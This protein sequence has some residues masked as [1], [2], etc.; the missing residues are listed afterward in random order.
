MAKR[1]FEA[2]VIRIYEPDMPKMVK[3]LR[4]VL[5]YKPPTR[6]VVTCES[7][8]APNAA[9]DLK[10]AANGDGL[11]QQVRAVGQ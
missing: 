7:H 2:E 1:P 6:E 9:E 8:T 10:A 5:D 3:A 11:Q 4:T